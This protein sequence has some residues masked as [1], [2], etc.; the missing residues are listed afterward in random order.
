[1]TSN[2]PRVVD[3]NR[4]IKNVEHLVE[5]I[6]DAD[7]VSATVHMVAD[8]VISQFRDQLGLY[9][10]RIYRREGDEFVLQGT[11][12]E[13]KE[14]PEGLRVAATY[15]PIRE[16][17][18]RRTLYM[19]EDDPLLDRDLEADLGVDQFVAIEVGDQEYILSFNVAPGYDKS[20]ILFS[21][22]ILRHS[23]NQ[24]IRQERMA[25]ALRQARR[26][27]ASIV[28]RGNPDFAGF[29]ICGRSI[30]METVG[31]DHFDFISMTDKVIGLAIADVSGHGLPAALQVRDIYMGLRMGL[32]RDY[33]IVRTVERLNEIIHLSTL[34]SRFVSMVYGELEASGNFVYVNCGHPPPFR[35]AA[36]GELK[37]LE[38]G[39]I[40][41]GPIPDA[42]Y[43]R[44]FVKV[45]PGDLLVFYTD[46]IVEAACSEAGGEPE[47][48]GLERLM[49]AAR[50]H[51][52]ESAGQVVQAILDRLEA[53]CDGAPA[54]D[55]RTVVV[56]KRPPEGQQ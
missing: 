33:K 14:V 20:S 49:E 3:Y 9:G 52:S 6:E 8:A 35:V 40:V 43:E 50:D 13:A 51:Q 16:L 5:A 1:M 36:S 31:G 32:S 30:P 11:F 18:Q 38:R 44:G 29:D 2:D 55:D 10:G 41:L 39:G 22:G 56:V 17:I 42:T 21:L 23:I 54:E 7:D 48:F 24:K 27:Q 26:I 45:R 53:F 34:T 12:G 25:D 47:E 4:L 28:P 15:G 46:G 37:L 19:E